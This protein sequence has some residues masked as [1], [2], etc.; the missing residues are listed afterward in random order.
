MDAF[1]PVLIL[2][3]GLGTRIRTLAGN[4]PKSLVPVN[5]RPFIDWQLQLLRRQGATDVVL[6]VAHEA[7]AIKHH[8]RDGG[9]FNLRVRYS[10]DGAILVGTGG[11]ARRASANLDSPF[12]VLYG[13]SYLDIPLQPIVSEFARCNKPALMTV[14][15]NENSLIPSNVLYEKGTIVKY[16]KELKT[17]GMKHVDFGFS[18]FRP[19]AFVSFSDRE[20][21]DLGELFQSLIAAG[22]LAGYETT[23]RFYEVGTPEGVRDLEQYLTKQAAAT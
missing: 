23:K 6:C 10:E 4:L 2:A 3:G 22:Q 12:A 16:D 14:F 11:A 13:D 17:N 7:D 21:F 15:K 5:G 18:L 8:V 9:D 19:E 1:P 20:K